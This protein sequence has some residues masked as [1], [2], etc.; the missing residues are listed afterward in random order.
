MSDTAAEHE[1]IVDQINAIQSN[2]TAAATDSAAV[3]GSADS[4]QDGSDAADVEAQTNADNS[5][6]G[7]KYDKRKRRRL[8]ELHEDELWHCTYYPC[9]KVYSM[10]ST[11]SIQQ[12]KKT[13]VLAQSHLQMSQLLPMYNSM[14]YSQKFAP[15][16][17]Y[18]APLQ[19]Y[20]NPALQH[21]Q[22]RLP[23][24]IQQQIQLATSQHLPVSTY[25]LHD[26][27]TPHTASNTNAVLADT[28]LLHAAT[29]PLI[30][31]QPVHQ[32]HENLANSNQRVNFGAT[33]NFAQLTH[34]AIKAH[35]LN[36]TVPAQQP[37]ATSYT[38]LMQQLQQ[39]QQAQM[40]Y[41]AQPQYTAANSKS[42]TN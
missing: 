37:A 38:Q 41:A 17:G 15:P 40:Q 27:Y 26:P 29:A 42:D 5:D 20:S 4:V 36:G 11:A 13:C 3:T 16:A 18:A 14:L 28:R 31:N 6:T 9:K 33:V 39:A 12:H 34:E 35:T 30:P 8:V 22:Q 24:Q 7:S 2:H 21:A 32:L 25:A 23:P 10:K 1:S 19:F